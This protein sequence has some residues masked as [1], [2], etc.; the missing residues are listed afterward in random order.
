MSRSTPTAPAMRTRARWCFDHC[1]VPFCTQ[2]SYIFE[3]LGRG[4]VS[5]FFA[6]YYCPACDRETEREFDVAD[7]IVEPTLAPPRLNCPS[8]DKQMHF[9]PVPEL[10]L[11]FAS[12]LTEGD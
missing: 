7:V 6:P 11:R 10:Y 9:E 3:F 4:E 2:A 5:S 8:C 12:G 1:S